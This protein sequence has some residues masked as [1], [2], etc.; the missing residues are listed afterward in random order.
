MSEYTYYDFLSIQR[1]L[2]S[3]EQ[4]ALDRISS[5]AEVTSRTFSVTYSYGGD[6][7]AEPLDL[8]ARYFDLF[9]KVDCWGTRRVALRLPKG[10]LT[11]EQVAPY[12]T[13]SAGDSFKEHGEHAI[14]DLDLDRDYDYDRDYTG[15]VEGEGVI[16][17]IAGIYDE[18]LRGDMRPLYIAWLYR[19]SNLFVE[20]D[21]D[22]DEGEDFEDS[23]ASTPEPPLP[24]GLQTLTAAQQHLADFF[25]L[26]PLLLAA[27][28][29]ASPPLPA[30]PT[31]DTL[32]EPLRALPTTEKDRLLLLVLRG[33]STQA[34][35]ALHTHLR[36]GASSQAQSSPP[37]RTFAAINQRADDLQAE[38]DA[39]QAAEQ[40]RLLNERLDQ[41][42][43]RRRTAWTEITDILNSRK[44]SLYPRVINQLLDLQRLAVRDD[45]LDKFNKELVEL[46]DKYARLTSFQRLLLDANLRKP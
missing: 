32:P 26:H 38:H 13:P 44:N 8:L 34:A 46:T 7:R 22:I 42:A 19:I 10:A 27:A 40:T 18:L 17:T 30:Q 33:E 14:L 15:Y 12:F 9:L 1:P 35:T 39:Q 43:R 29:E 24:P 16:H 11:A 45:H 25:E 2:T 20:D 3:T 36:E 5:H 4:K 6:L 23:I 21:Y 37:P 28:A 31:F 41:L